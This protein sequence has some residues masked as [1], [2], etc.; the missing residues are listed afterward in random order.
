[1]GEARDQ[2]PHFSDGYVDTGWELL[3]TA[4]TIVYCIEMLVKIMT[5]SWKGFIES[6]RNRFDFLI[7]VLAVFA[8]AYVYY[9]NKFSDSRLIRYIV[10]ARVLRLARLLIAMEGF[11]V[12]GGTF[13]DVLPAATRVLL[14]LFCIM[15]TF[16]AVGMMLFGGQITRDPQNPLSY[17][18]QDTDFSDN[19]YWANNFNDM[20]SGVNVLFNLLVVNNWPEQADGLLAVTQSKASRLFFLAFHIIAV[21]LINNIVIAFII[22]S[23]M[24]E[25]NEYHEKKTERIDTGEAVITSGARAIFD[26]SEVTGTKTELQGG[27]VAKLRKNH[28]GQREAQVLKGFFTRSSSNVENDSSHSSHSSFT[29]T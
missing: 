1:M 7:T 27:Y 13:Q 5:Q 12:I 28:K 23:F 21:I 9:P 19:A 4:F 18:L 24:S 3:E 16:A 25:W 22:D 29:S 11:R 2:N 6:Q 17:R 14:L 15:Y 10:M 20:C 8:T 26:A